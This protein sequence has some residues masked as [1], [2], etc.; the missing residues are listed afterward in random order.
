MSDTTTISPVKRNFNFNGL[1]LE[2]PDPSMPPEKVLEFHALL[3]HPELTNAQLKG[4]IIGTNGEQTYKVEL[5]VG[6]DG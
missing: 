2:D 3:N 6:K 4:P 1:K 5:K